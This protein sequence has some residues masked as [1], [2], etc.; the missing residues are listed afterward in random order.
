MKTELKILLISFIILI[1]L[2]FI[3]LLSLKN[4]D[5]FS[6]DTKWMAH[7]REVSRMLSENL[8]KIQSIET[9]YRG[10]VITGNKNYLEPYD[11]M[12]GQIRSNIK[13]LKNLTKENPIQQQRI[14]TLEHISKLK[15]VYSKIIIEVREKNGFEAAMKVVSTEEGRT[16]MDKIR[17]ITHSMQ[18]EEEDLLKER[19]KIT[20]TSLSNTKILIV[21][22][23]VFSSIVVVF[24]MF[25]IGR[26]LRLKRELTSEKEHAEKLVGFKD[27][28]LANMS[29]EIRTP[30]NGIIGFTKI[31]LRNGIT[32]KQKQ[33][34]SAIKTS[35]DILLVLIN[36]ILDLA[37]IE[38]GK[39]TL[40]TTE[41]KLSEL[42]N[43]IVGTFEIRFLEKEFKIKKAYGNSIPIILLGD[44][45]RINQI[46]LNLL[47]NSIKFTEKGGEITISVNQ[48]EQD[49][50]KTVIEFIV[51]DTGIG[52]PPDR[53]ETIFEP[54]TQSSSD[55][56]RR[57]GGTGLG[58][59]IVKRLIDM[60]GGTI[61]VES[62]VKKGSTFTV[63]LPFKKSTVTGLEKEVETKTQIQAS[64]SQQLGKL[65]ILL[66][67]DIPI[68]QF[69]AQT[70]LHDFDFETDTAENGKIAIELL[71]K[72][73]YDIILMDLMMPEMT[74]FEAT[75]YIRNKMQSPKSAIPIIA[76]TA[77]VTKVDVD[78]CK[79]VGM[80]EYVSK[81][82]NEIELLNKITQLMKKKV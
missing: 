44:S 28:F 72:N 11:E 68:N 7:T 31:L 27:Q 56:A 9:G 1:A 47:S 54:F 77:D 51:S 3:T 61:S 63:T 5:R 18:E 23:G 74:G 80:N 22:G 52:I 76:L 39:M 40:E 67:E 17:L 36:D 35:S 10:Y 43:S 81:P 82:I 16:L 53:L 12:V 60:M 62:Q 4:I 21:L 59:S 45:V 55:T 78:K 2:I 71:E 58:L 29:H 24:L 50:E 42:V 64:E 66:V 30:L 69:L 46:L 15:I 19:T 75:E 73:H 25:Y 38:A 37:K 65:K 34:L 57:F 6:N 49:E 26:S 32:E 20:D 70:I 33:Q 41:L 8:S 14:D 48:K 13:Q 79:E